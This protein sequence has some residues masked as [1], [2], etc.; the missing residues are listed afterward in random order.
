[1]TVEDLIKAKEEASSVSYQSFVLLT[2]TSP[3]ALFCFFEGKD[4]PYYHFRIKTFCTKQ[5]EYISCGGKKQVLK[6]KEIID[7]HQEYRNYAK[8]FFIDLDFDESQKDLDNFLY[9]TP[10][11]SIEN[12]YCSPDSFADI[13]KSEF[14]LI[15]EDEGYKTALALYKKRLNEFSD[16]I[17]LFNSWYSLQKEKQRKLGIN[18]NVNL[19]DKP[20][21]DFI[22]IELG[23]IR[24][25]YD[26]NKIRQKFDESIP[27]ID[28]DV[29]K[30]MTEL[31]KDCLHQRL[32]GKYYF[33][34]LIH[35]LRSI[36]DDA[37]NKD[38][39][40]YLKK[41]V[42]FNIDQISALST[43]SSYAETPNCLREYLMSLN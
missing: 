27:V 32:R 28:E 33:H 4:A 36:I 19:S 6:T 24:A 23:Q 5:T 9:E 12:F 26:L 31:K 39:Q 34:F 38:K 40:N 15:K 7:S 25:N 13:L 17:L 10:C 16:S 1:M 42:K 30:R 8:S 29:E 22:N 3:D 2:S 11:Y 20:P 18:N 41:K 35:F 43:L 14:L 21:K 37:N